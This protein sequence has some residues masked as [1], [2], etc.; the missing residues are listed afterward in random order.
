MVQFGDHL[1]SSDGIIS[2]PGSFAVLGSFADPYSVAN[3]ATQCTPYLSHVI[4]KLKYFHWM[5]AQPIYSLLTVLNHFY[6]LKR[7]AKL[8]QGSNRNGWQYTGEL[9]FVNG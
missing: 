9:Q 1:R 3:V 8:K 7:T 4:R 6:R 2:G 5:L